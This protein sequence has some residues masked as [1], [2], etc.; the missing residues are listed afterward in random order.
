MNAPL[1]ILSKKEDITGIN[2]LLLIIFNPISAAIK[3]TNIFIKEFIPNTLVK[4][5]S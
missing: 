1:N 2:I 4:Y 3:Q 5:K